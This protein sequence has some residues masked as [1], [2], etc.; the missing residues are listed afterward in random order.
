MLTRKKLHK[1][2][3]LFE[4]ARSLGWK[5]IRTE[6]LYISKA[7]KIVLVTVI[8]CCTLPTWVTWILACYFDGNM[9]KK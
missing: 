7:L 6:D 4:D 2:G 3:I 9:S 5:V 1:I 8:L